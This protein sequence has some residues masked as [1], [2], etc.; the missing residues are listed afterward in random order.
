[1]HFVLPVIISQQTAIIPLYNIYR[2]VFVMKTE[3]VLYEAAGSC[4][5][6]VT[7]YQKYS[8]TSMKT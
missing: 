4:A 7:I 8:A 2:L 5:M 1:M 6:Y 3:F